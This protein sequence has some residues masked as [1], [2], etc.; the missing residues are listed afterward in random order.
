MQK[1]PFIIELY[2]DLCLDFDIKLGCFVVSD[3]HDVAFL[4]KDGTF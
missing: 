4:L 1:Y 2:D 3:W